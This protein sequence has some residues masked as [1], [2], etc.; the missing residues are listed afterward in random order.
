MGPETVGFALIVVVGASSAAI[1][2]RAR[3]VPNALTYPAAAIG[4]ALAATPWSRVGLG[5]SLA[6]CAIGVLLMLVPYGFGFTGGGDVKLFGALATLLGPAR[7]GAAFVYAALAGGVVALGVASWR[8][9]RGAADRYFAYA[10][11]IAIGAIAAALG[12]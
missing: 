8:R 5:A 3:H 12:G 10:P 2:V 4:V 9:R 6:G 1:D 7:T 11:A